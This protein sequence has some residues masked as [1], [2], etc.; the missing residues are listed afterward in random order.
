MER[1][2]HH[3]SRIAHRYED[4]RTTD[5]E[6]VSFIK[7]KL[8]NFPKIEA[9]DIGCGVGRYDMQLFRHLKK[10]LYLTCIDYNLNMLS[11]LIRNLKQYKIKNFKVI[12]ASAM[13]LPLETNSLD[14]IV[15]FNAV[16]HFKFLD[17]LRETAR[18]LRDNGYLFIY[19]R[20]RTQNKRNIWGRFFPQFHEKENRL[21]EINEF[22]ELLKKIPILL[23]ESIEY[24]KY[25][26]VAKLEWLITQATHHHYSTFY[27][28]DG[29]EFEEAL[30]KFQGNITRHFESPE[31]IIWN[32][33]NIMFIIRKN[34][35]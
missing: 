5:L 27:L 25:K 33:E 35:R 1:I 12:N 22:K 26:R 34:V 7:K 10:R 24:F 6:P 23:L 18:I 31:N 20:L 28:Y 32:D 8:Q 2:H 21:Y 4:I 16:H 19:T 13:A 30:R 15:T 17:F 14:A 9:A 3:F 29:K 11:E